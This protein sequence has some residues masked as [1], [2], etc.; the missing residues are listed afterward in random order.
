MPGRI[1]GIDRSGAP[2]RSCGDLAFAGLIALAPQRPSPYDVPIAALDSAALAALR[3]RYFPDLQCPLQAYAEAGAPPAIDEFEDLLALLLDHR[4]VA[5]RKHLAGA[6]ARH[7]LHGRKSSVARHGITESFHALVAIKHHFTSLAD[8]NRGDMKWKK[9]FYRQLCE[10]EGLLLCKSPN[11]ESCT[12]LQYVSALKT[13]TVSF[14]CNSQGHQS[15]QPGGCDI[16]IKFLTRE[17]CKYQ[18]RAARSARIKR[19]NARLKNSKSVVIRFVG[20][21]GDGMMLTGT[22]FSMAVAKAGH[23]FATH[24]DYPSEVRAPTGTLFGVSG[25]QIQYGVVT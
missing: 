15:P 3:E 5:T 16:E 9:F 13:R 11:C 14:R 21:S 2:S 20:D 1:C 24:P 4:T 7:S 6:C 25:Y 10:R 17:L 12:D 19:C 22:G 23:D 18:Y 8:R